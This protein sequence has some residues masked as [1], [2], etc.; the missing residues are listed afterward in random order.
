MP[1]FLL[2]FAA[3]AVSAA[4]MIST[5]GP[6]V[7]D[8]HGD[9]RDDR[10]EG[11]WDR[12]DDRRDYRDYDRYRQDRY[13]Y[14]PRW[15]YAPPPFPY[16]RDREFHAWRRGEYLPPVHRRFA[17]RDYGYY[18][19]RPPPPGFYWYQVDRSFLLIDLSSGLIFESVGDYR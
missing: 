16:D 7:A 12:Y 2:A 18:R 8:P 6:A 17:I 4:T 14:N 15:G 11:R 9:R 13:P 3:L 5:A 19:L 10:H 1:R